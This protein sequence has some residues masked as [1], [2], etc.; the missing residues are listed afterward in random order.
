MMVMR[1]FNQDYIEI[2]LDKA[3][4]IICLYCYFMCVHLL[5]LRFLRGFLL[6]WFLVRHSFFSL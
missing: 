4:D 5:E 1:L 3:E 2:W 6:T